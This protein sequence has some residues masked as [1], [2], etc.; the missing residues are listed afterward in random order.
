MGVVFRWIELE[1]PFERGSR[2]L[3]LAGVEIRPAEGFKDRCLAGLHAI[4]A[5]EDDRRLRMMSPVEQRAAPLQQ[6][7]GG[8]GGRLLGAG[9]ATR[10][11]LVVHAE[12]VAR[13]RTCRR[14]P[15]VSGLDRPRDPPA[16]AVGSR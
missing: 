13:N 2:R 14:R 12:M 6:L 5:L 15:A 1:Q 11:V 3:V 9:L 4:G 7:V 10:S 16:S 8:L